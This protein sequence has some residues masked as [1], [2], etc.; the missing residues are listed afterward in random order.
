MGRNLRQTVGARLL[1]SKRVIAAGAVVCSLA[2]AGFALALTLGAS[3]ATLTATGPSPQTITANWGDTVS[4]VNADTVAH[5][6]TSSRPELNAT[7]QPG[8]T[9]TTV[10]TGR[11]AT[12]S[13]RQTATVGRS[14]PGDVVSQV[15]G[16]VNLK[17]S[18][19]QVVYGKAVDRK[20]VV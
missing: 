14:K 17:A 12:Y 15:I 18:A 3:S 13:Y 7:I 11:T 16:S 5:G 20:S 2:F 8:Q 19:G 10:L 9:F 6:I 1:G 4:F